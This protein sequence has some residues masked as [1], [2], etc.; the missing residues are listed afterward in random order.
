MIPNILFIILTVIFQQMPNVTIHQ[1][2]TIVKLLERKANGTEQTVKE[3]DGYRVQVFS[4]NQQQQAKAEALQMEKTL[5]EQLTEEIYVSYS[6]PF[7]KV[8]IGNYR[9]HEAAMR[10]KEEI[11]R[12]LPELQSSTYVVK[13]KIQVKE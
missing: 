3:I 10:A 9:T 8:R 4:S 12:A 13:D 6:T 2:S 5:R 1:D 7:W 11:I